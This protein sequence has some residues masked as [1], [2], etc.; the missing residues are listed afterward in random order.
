MNPQS[1]VSTGGRLADVRIVCSD[2]NLRDDEKG[3]KARG[4]LAQYPGQFALSGESNP[5]FKAR[6]DCFRGAQ[7]FERFQHF[8]AYSEQAIPFF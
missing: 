4:V 3:R 5:R 6:G 2:F 8:L 7:R 1:I